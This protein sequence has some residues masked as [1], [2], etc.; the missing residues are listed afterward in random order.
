[1]ISLIGDLLDLSS[2][3]SADIL[4]KSRVETDEI[5]SRILKQIQG[6][7]D[8]KSQKVEAQFRATLVWADTRRLEQVLVNLLDNANKYTPAEGKVVV[9]WESEG[10]D[11]LLKVKDSG[12]G[13]PPEHHA[14]LFE[15]F[16]RVDKA[17]SRD[18][19]GT[20][21]G[22]AIVKHILQRHEGAVWVE[23]EIGKGA[24]FVC[25]FPGVAKAT[26]A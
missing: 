22:L 1:L 11:V 24:T 25:R 20:G 6:K 26:R 8:A 18:L 16:Y 13:I 2:L 12:P 15:R 7:F 5:T 17:R 9:S 21:L 23:S 4:H 14:R 3:E 10:A 19:G